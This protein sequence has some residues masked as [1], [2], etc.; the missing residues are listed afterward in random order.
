MTL[1]FDGTDGALLRAS[2]T[3]DLGLFG[4]FY[5]GGDFAFEKSTQSLEVTGAGSST[6]FEVLTIGATGV[7]GFV[8]INTLSPAGE[9]DVNGHTRTVTLQVSGGSPSIGDIL[10][11]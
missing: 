8:G 5:L 7:N 10:T 9:L 2:G 4:F 6:S 11:P 1:D 3:V